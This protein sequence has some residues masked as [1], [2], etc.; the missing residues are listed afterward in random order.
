MTEQATDDVVIYSTGLVYLSACVAADVSDDDAAGRVN[1]MHPTG[2]TPWHVS[3]D[4]QFRDGQA[5][6]SPCEQQPDDRRH[7]LFEC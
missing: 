7:M 4:A 5:N 3:A 1:L 2:V 6:P